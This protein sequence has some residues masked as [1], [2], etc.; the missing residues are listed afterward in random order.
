MWYAMASVGNH[1]KVRETLSKMDVSTDSHFSQSTAS[2]K[3]F[4]LHIEPDGSKISKINLARSFHC[5]IT[6]FIS[7][8]YKIALVIARLSKKKQKWIHRSITDIC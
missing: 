5:L 4:S 3:I 2:S 1:V 6:S 7:T 8:N